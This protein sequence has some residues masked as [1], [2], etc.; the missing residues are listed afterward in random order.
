MVYEKSKAS[1]KG[2]FMKRVHNKINGFISYIAFIIENGINI[3]SEDR[4][5]LIYFFS[6]FA[7]N[8]LVKLTTGMELLNVRSF[9]FNF[10]W[11]ALVVAISYLFKIHKKRVGYFITVTSLQ[12]VF[13]FANLLYFRYYES[14]LSL[15]LF[16]Q[17]SL[18]A[19]M[20][21]S[22]EMGATLITTTDIVLWVLFIIS[23][24]FIVRC[25]KQSCQVYNEL[26]PANRKFNKN[27][28]ARMSL[29]S[30]ISAV[31]TLQGAQYSQIFKMWNRPIVVENYGLAN[32]HIADA[33]RSITVFI[34]PKLKESDY[35]KFTTYF[36]NKN[37]NNKTN[38]YTGIFKNKNVIVIHAESIEKFLINTTFE[39][40]ELTPNINKLA[41]TGYYYSNFYSQESIGTS[42]DSEFVFNASL[43]PINNG[44][45]FLDNFDH[46]YITTQSLLQDN[47]Y[48]VFSFHGNNGSFWNRSIMHP[49][50]GYDQLFDKSYYQFDE[51]DTIGLG[52]SD[53]QFFKQTVNHLITLD[54]EPFYA[55]LITLTNHT[56]F[57]ALDKYVTY[58]EN[59]NEQEELDCG[60][61]AD[62]LV[63]NYLKSVRY[64][65]Y[66]IGQFIKSLESYKM[67]DDTII[68]LYGDHPANMPITDMEKFYGHSLSRIEY[69]AQQQVPFIIWSKDITEPKEIDT[70][71]GM[72]DA[73]PTLQ[74]MLGIRNQFNL[75]NDI[76]SV[77]ENI[78]PFINGDWVDGTIYYDSFRDDYVLLKE[79]FDESLI[80]NDYIKSQSEKAEKIVQI[81]NLIN[82][83][84]LINEYFD[85]RNKPVVKE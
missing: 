15:S 45:I 1:R 30:F 48:S 60:P 51:E 34:E 3:I 27:I 38:D 18:F 47:G 35:K 39:G 81:S 24:I 21:D 82:K 79:D 61:V 66:A 26:S 84:D 49:V 10:A 56:P 7:L 71:M 33:F 28:L 36:D 22:D 43:L 67:L 4:L 42:A 50:L 76:H 23:L 54:A 80:T 83:F 29:I 55:T 11:F 69:K 59:G 44:T 65:D 57:G 32:Y 77:K 14:F 85:R 72:L 52:I 70:V 5:L 6:T 62:E 20:P 74:N 78:V 53:E 40:Q 8:V 46:T 17:L 19:A 25:S 31:F 12:Y 13:T 73:P 9:L 63:C 41:N 75:G 37:N 2:D 68:V 58:D 16:K 64:S